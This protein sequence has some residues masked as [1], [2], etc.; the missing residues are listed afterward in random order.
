MLGSYISRL[1]DVREENKPVPETHNLST[2]VGHAIET[3]DAREAKATFLKTIATAFAESFVQTSC[4]IDP[5]LAV[6]DEISDLVNSP[7]LSNI[8]DSARRE[9][10][11]ENRRRRIRSRFSEV[12]TK[13]QEKIQ[14][15]ICKVLLVASDAQ[16]VT[17]T[18]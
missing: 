13:K 1:V 10:A 9:A 3:V 7:L 8:I 2:D 15:L 4:E 12:L 14:E 6:L 11:A 17:G 18:L 5:S 16:T